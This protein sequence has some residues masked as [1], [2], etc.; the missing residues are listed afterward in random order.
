M[1]PLIICCHISSQH[2]LAATGCVINKN[3]LFAEKK[4][5]C[6]QLGTYI[7]IV[8][9]SKR[10]YRFF[11]LSQMR[12]CQR[13]FW[14][15]RTAGWMVLTKARS[16][17]RLKPIPTLLSVSALSYTHTCT[18]YVLYDRSIIEAY[19]WVLLR[20]HRTIAITCT[21][22]SLIAFGS[23]YFIL[24]SPQSNNPHAVSESEPPAGLSKDDKGLISIVL[25]PK[26]K[27]WMTSLCST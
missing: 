12:C 13:T 26:R 3:E 18:Q 9:P 11:S 6:L 4:K 20:Q 10:V 16:C 2:R 14:T 19:F 1:N 21:T 5:K 27:D 7:I 22:W 15:I 8:F 23:A 25:L 17:G 24:Q